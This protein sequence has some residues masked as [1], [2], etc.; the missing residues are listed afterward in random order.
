[1]DGVA[2]GLA[3]SAG[4]LSVANPCALAMI[5]AYVALRTQSATGGAAPALIVNG[6]GGLLLG[7]VGVFTLTG[8]AISLA[9]R[10]LFQLVPF[11]AG[12]VGLA[13]VWAGVRTLL[14][15]PLHVPLPAIAIRGGAESLP[16][17]LVFG[18]TYGLASLGCALPVFLAYTISVASGTPLAFALN[19]AAFAA[20]AALTLLVVVVIALAAQGAGGRIPAGRELARYGGG[21]L[22]TIAGVYV[23]YLQLGWV[24][25]YPLGVPTLTLPV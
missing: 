15:R 18:A 2:V 7:F 1:M 10:T 25:G 6:V 11:V 13:L 20:G 23:A 16:G 19:L 24:I 5:P 14:G 12:A 8:L 3:F 17:Q 21:L 4:A 9:G 22:V